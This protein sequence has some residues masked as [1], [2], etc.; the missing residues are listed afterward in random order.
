M[1]SDN[2]EMDQVERRCR[3]SNRSKRRTRAEKEEWP[4]HTALQKSHSQLSACFNVYRKQQGIHTFIRVTK[5]I[6]DWLMKS[7]EES[8]KEKMMN[9]DRVDACGLA[10]KTHV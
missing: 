5:K 6:K 10:V 7:Q 1:E 9:M 3:V 2:K 8:M 4:I